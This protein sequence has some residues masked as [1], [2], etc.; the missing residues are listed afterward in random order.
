MSLT[1]RYRLPVAAASRAAV[2]AYDRGARALL[3]FGADTIG[4]F[5]EALGHDPDFALARAGLAVSLC[6]DEKIPGG[7]AA[8]DAAVVAAR[9]LTEREPRHIEALIVEVGGSHAQ[10]ELFHD[11]L[12]AAALRAELC[13]RARRL[14]DRRLAK[15][16]NPGHYGTTVRSAPSSE[17]TRA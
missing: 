17:R 15:R 5:R 16:P 10:R 13:D 2:D 7:R 12:L 4:A 9:A 1:D 3:G 8:M 14:L 6:L 11:T